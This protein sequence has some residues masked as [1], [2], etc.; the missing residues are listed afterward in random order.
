MEQRKHY[1]A[2]FEYAASFSGPSLRG[3]GII[4]NLSVVGCRARSS[5]VV[6]KN[7]ALG[8]LIN[9]PRYQHPLYISHAIVRWSHEQE[10]GVEFIQMELVD[11][12]RLCDLVR[13]LK[14]TRWSRPTNGE[15]D[16]L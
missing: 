3:Q 9:V 11:Q 13:A 2:H 4:L 5:F 1:R 6:N 12:Q 8:V 10:F 7:D 14:A 16:T 15:S